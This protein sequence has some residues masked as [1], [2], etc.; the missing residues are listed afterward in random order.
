[1]EDFLGYISLG[2]S[3]IYIGEDLGFELDKVSKIA[4]E[5]NIQIRTFPNI[6][7][8]QWKYASSLKST[9]SPFL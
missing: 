3:D 9:P 7:Q 8:T 1:M 5:H 4:K 6:V 2:V